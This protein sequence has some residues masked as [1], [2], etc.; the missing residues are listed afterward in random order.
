MNDEP[1]AI[2]QSNEVQD[3]AKEE[4]SPY[5]DHRVIAVVNGLGAPTPTSDLEQSHD[6]N[7]DNNGNGD[8]KSD[9]EAETVVL[10]GKD[11]ASAKV[12][13]NDSDHEGA[14]EVIVKPDSPTGTNTT[15]G[16]STGTISLKRKRAVPNPVT[17]ALPDVGNSSNLSSTISSPT[18]EAQSS[19]RAISESI[20]SRSTPP[21]EIDS[22]RKD[23]QSRKRKLQV[24]DI[25]ENGR[26]R[27]SKRDTS[28]DAAKRHERRESRK[29]NQRE[30][31]DDR[32]VSP[33]TRPQDRAQS[34]QTADIRTV[35]KR[36]KPPPLLVGHR[37]KDSED[38]H[39]D[40][41]DSG[42][43]QG[44]VHLHKFA[45]ADNIAMSP[46]KIP[47]KKHRDKN[48]RTWLARACATEEVEVA[49]TRLKERPEDLDVADNAGN[50]PLQIASLEGNADIVQVLLDAGCDTACKNID[51][52]TPLI[53]AVEN[54]H[55]DVVKLLLR[56]GLDPRQSNSKGEEPLDLLKPG[57]EDNDAIRTILLEAK[58]KDTRRR[59]S[60][61]QHG[62]SSAGNRDSASAPSPRGSPPLLSARSPPFHATAPRRRTA[63]SEATR[64][65]LLWINPTPE[66]LRDRAGKGDL[67]GVDHILNMRPTADTEAVLAAARGGHEVVLQL[68][69]AIGKP[70][71]DPEPLQSS[72]YKVGHNTP[73]LAAIGRGN[74]RVIQLLLAQPDFD[75]SRRLYRGLTYHEIAKERQGSNWQEEVEILQGAYDLYTSR[76]TKMVSKGTSTKIRGVADGHDPKRPKRATSSSSP[77]AP[78][79]VQS[80]DSTTA[81]VTPAWRTQST[82]LKRGSP[83][84]EAGESQSS[85]KHL[86]VPDGGS[87]E[88]S[89]AVSDRETTHLGPPKTKSKAKR[90]HSEAGMAV[91]KVDTSKPRRRL[92]SGKTIKNDQEKRRRASMISEASSSSSNKDHGKV[93]SSDDVTADSEAKWEDSRETSG[94]QLIDSGKKRPHHSLS[95]QAG[96]SDVGTKA[97]DPA[98][99]KKRRRLD[100]TGNAIDRTLI[101]HPPHSRA[102]QVAN[103]IVSPQLTS[104]LPN[105]GTAPVAFM[106]N[107]SPVEQSSASRV[108]VD[109][110]SPIDAADQALQQSKYLQDLQAQTQAEEEILR[111]QRLVEEQESSAQR[112]ARARAESE[113]RRQLEQDALAREAK[114]KAALEE[115]ERKARVARQEEESRLEEQRRLEEAERK[116]RLERE[117]EEAR[118]EKKRKD[119]DMLR[120]RVEL[121]RLRKE[122]EDRRRAEQ[123]ERERLARIRRQ[124]EEERRRRESLPNS[125]RRAAE[126]SPEAA[127][128]TLEITKWLP[129]FT[130]T[131]QQLNPDCE[132]QARDERWIANIQAAPILAITDLDLS[133]CKYGYSPRH[134]T[135]WLCHALVIFQCVG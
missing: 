108:R 131:G 56:A 14:S 54:G 120:R 132:E 112:E 50:T 105:I 1:I 4:A 46:A 18:H 15:E 9:S 114:E 39:A 43:L 67:E 20:H 133:Q 87:R 76:G 88:S 122:N 129:L 135:I 61:D 92:V 16:D 64:N 36:K 11:E 34:T 117:E 49:I 123:E 89:N 30:S 22:H 3:K 101:E 13:R 21:H 45:S 134:S 90:S 98:K 124:E 85:R 127:R 70:E 24:D 25:D 55:L 107:P 130:V 57:N 42:S 96:T 126:L 19:T 33:P 102:A 111:Q 59:F 95:P 100:S 104:A 103:M 83:R 65:D 119:E 75:P 99:K 109:T 40:S 44:P 110:G 63:R 35:A 82:E 58:E 116:A 38:P 10:S 62:Q 79:K 66:N 47:H 51:M 113:E 86:K 17:G 125:L 23:G 48:G 28:L 71:Q 118:I 29:Q 52:D 68:L 128:N 81:G 26:R 53:D 77:L 84:P 12:N 78:A 60:E 8:S 80:P 37:R 7:G 93:K 2:S 97:L 27:R 74:V 91:A 5:E 106:G 32:S 69:I 73:M 115:T 94:N 121:E 6:I 41:D 31:S 72:A